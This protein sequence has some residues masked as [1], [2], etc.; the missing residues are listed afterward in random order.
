MRKLFTIFLIT[1]ALSAT[2]QRPPVET[3]TSAR[4]GRI[5]GQI[6]DSDTQQP[7]EYANIAIYN[8]RDSSLVTGG[9]TNDKGQFDIS[10]LGFGAYFAEANFIGYEKT[11]LPVI[12]IIPATQ[13]VDV[14]KVVLNPSTI[15]MEGI[16]VVAE[17]QR[18][19]YQIDKKV[20]NV[21]QDI[22]AAGGTAVDVLENTPSVEVDIDGNVLLRG[23]SSFTVLIDGR[24]SVLS[25]ND[26]L[27]QIPASAIENIE[28]IT[29]PSAKYDPDG[30]AGIINIVMRK[31]IL[32][33]FNGIINAMVG[34]R[35][36]YRSDLTMNY[37]TKKSNLF[38]GADWNEDNS[39]GKFFSDRE[40]FGGDTSLF[41]ISD[42][43]RDFRR[44]GF[45]IRAGVDLFLTDNATLTLSGTGGQFGNERNGGSNLREYTVPAS[46][47]KY[48]INNNLSGREGNVFNTNINFQQK[49]NTEG[50]H[51]LDALFYFSR[52][53]ADDSEEQDEYFTDQSYKSNL[54]FIDRLRSTETEVS[55]EF[56]LKIDYVKP[57]NGKGKIEAGLQSTL[58]REEEDFKFE[59][60]N[61][62]TS[63]WNNNQMF[64]NALT[65]R[66]DIH[67]GYFTWS[68][69]LKKLQYM[70]GLR[71]EYTFRE[72]DHEKVENPYT[73]NRFD[74]FPTGHVSLQAAKSTQLMASF[75]RR[76]N[77]PSG[78]DLDPF[79]TY[80]NQYTIRI[81]NPAL[82]PEYSMSY[83]MSVMQRF[84]TSFISGELFYRT[85]NNLISR[86]QELREDGIIYMT[87]DNVNRDFSMGTEVMGNFNVT[88]WLLL[89]TSL[90]VFN[91]RIDGEL[92][93]RSIDRESTNYS[94]RMNGNVRLSADSRIQLTAF[95]RGPSVQPQGESSSMFFSN[96]SYRH[97][98]LDK[99]L[100]A[101]LSV[102]DVFGTSRFEGKTFAENFTNNFRFERESQVVQLTLSYRINNYRAERNNGNG[103]GDMG[104]GNQGRMDME[105]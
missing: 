65:F 94:L 34:T 44:N 30:Q 46:V 50:T 23:S 32:A 27:R 61:P 24:P 68:G 51:K 60:Y 25:G 52:R 90:S 53:N 47:N 10:G 89:N 29:N 16:D 12:R 82:K 41:I 36:K 40:N 77:R 55:N 45:N 85:T 22:N 98:F 86:I 96:I 38:F 42:G 59:N 63:S 72:I 95:Y 54:G 80:M 56:R 48:M 37:R 14:G 105:F 4:S 2:A 64:T 69:S 103:N 92:N 31:N 8:L 97:E 79:P 17:R 76:I 62:T 75:S 83:Q 102:R 49:F 70:T 6:I 1:V 74:L 43:S 81:G 5:R 13:T 18:I 99:K 93:G 104:G 101:T 78:G 39:Y 9:I 21:R 67:A 66:R 26:A 7:M 91:Y 11:S 33:G 19:E 87:T 84:G 58:D 100:S 71:G 15:R 28:I 88:K 3:E 73:I 35:D 20:V 57:V